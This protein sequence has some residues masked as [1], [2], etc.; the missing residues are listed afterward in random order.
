MLIINS[1][2]WQYHNPRLNIGNQKPQCR[3]KENITVL[4]CSHS[5]FLSPFSV[6]ECY[7]DVRRCGGFSLM[8]RGTLCNVDTQS[9]TAS[10]SR[11]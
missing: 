2:V 11:K 8:E 4:G 1:G 10:Q 3:N 5:N 7:L 6:S 9:Y